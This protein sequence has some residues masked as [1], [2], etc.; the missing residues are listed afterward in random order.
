M[1]CGLK[2]KMEIFVKVLLELSLV[3]NLMKPLVIQLLFCVI[4]LFKT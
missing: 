3:F 1:I 2:E 4:C